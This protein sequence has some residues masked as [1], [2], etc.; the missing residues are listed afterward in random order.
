MKYLKLTF[1]TLTVFAITTS[2]YGQNTTADQNLFSA[3]NTEKAEKK[4]VK[5]KVDAAK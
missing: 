2:S 1:I 3:L 4:E 5:K